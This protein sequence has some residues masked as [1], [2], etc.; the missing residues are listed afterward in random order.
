MV[1][2]NANPMQ[3]IPL[4][5]TTSISLIIAKTY[6]QAQHTQEGGAMNGVAEWG[7]E[8]GDTTECAN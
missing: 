6:S 7:A 1:L 2:W 3:I 4:Y 8:G 5:S